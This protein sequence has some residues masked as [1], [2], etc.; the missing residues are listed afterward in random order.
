MMMN[1]QATVFWVAMPCNDGVR[2][3]CFGGPCCLHLQ[4]EVSGA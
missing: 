1:I 3:Q 4:G 2:F